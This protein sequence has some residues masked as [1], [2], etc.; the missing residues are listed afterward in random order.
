MM[1]EQYEQKGAGEVKG[2]KQAQWEKERMEAA[3]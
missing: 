2:D 1:E 3:E